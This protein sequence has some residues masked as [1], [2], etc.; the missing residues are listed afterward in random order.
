[1]RTI[2]STVSACARKVCGGAIP[3]ALLVAVAPLALVLAPAQAA[4]QAPS[5]RAAS[6]ECGR[7]IPLATDGRLTLDRTSVRPG[8]SVLGI[9]SN[10]RQWP[11]GLIGGGSGETFESCATWGPN[12]ESE[13]LFHDAA[14]MFLFPVPL[15][16]KPGTYQVEVIFFQGSTDPM[17]Y[18]HRARLTTPVTVTTQPA[19]MP[20]AACRLHH[21]VAGPGALTAPATVQAGGDLTV[22][23]LTRRYGAYLNE[24]DRL[25][26]VACLNG[27]AT[28]I[29]HQSTRPRSFTVPVPSGLQPGS[30]DLVVT[31]LLPDGAGQVAINSWHSSVVVQAAPSS[32][33]PPPLAVTGADPWLATA[34]GLTLATAG[35]WLLLAAR[36]RATRTV[37]KGVHR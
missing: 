31:G 12:Q 7:N 10:F 25:Y 13:V 17:Q 37:L 3:L 27:R 34:L 36:R 29:A 1:M 8:D 30:Y 35:G 22:T 32:P 23:V 24:Y 21:G 26:F 14:G 16:T 11:E 2:R 33:S 18:E 20:S 4:A 15:G 28:V 6:A 5:A 19:D 9:L